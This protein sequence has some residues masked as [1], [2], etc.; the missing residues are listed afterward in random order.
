AV[1]GRPITRRRLSLDLSPDRLHLRLAESAIVDQFALFWPRGRIRPAA[2]VTRLMTDRYA[3][4]PHGYEYGEP[5]RRYVEQ[6]GSTRVMNTYLTIALLCV[7]LV[8]LGLIGLNIHTQRTIGNVKPLVIRIDDVGRA[9]AVS[10]ASLTYTPQAP[11]LK[12]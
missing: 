8:A 1:Y 7:S 2:S 11:E 5:R 4:P 6:Y 12:Y 3:L 10:Y 9:T